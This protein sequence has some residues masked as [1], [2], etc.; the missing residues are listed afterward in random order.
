MI[1]IDDC[2]SL[3]DIAKILFGKSNYTNREKSKKYLLENGIDWKEWLDSVKQSKIK[4]CIVCGKK[5]EKSQKLFCSHSCSASYNNKQREKKIK[6]CLNCGKEVEN[7]HKNTS[8]CSNECQRD[9]EYKQYI[10]AWKKGEESGLR[11]KWEMSSHIRRYML[12][13]TN[14]SCEICGCNWVN[15]KNGRPIVQIHHIDGDAFN[16]TEENLQVL[17]PNHHAMTENYGNNNKCG[18]KKRMKNAPLV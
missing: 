1:N 9:Y 2:K 13:K 16:N 4:Y 11:G 6:Q 7:Y 3:N 8:F 12:E 15:P 17:C 10:S 18:R 14:C 5:L